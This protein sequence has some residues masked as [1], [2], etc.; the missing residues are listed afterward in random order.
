MLSQ[1]RDG[2]RYGDGGQFTTL[3]EAFISQTHDRFGYGD[4]SQT[5]ATFEA[6]LS[7]TRDG[8]GDGDGSQTDATREFASRFVSAICKLNGRKVMMEILERMKK[9]KI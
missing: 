9:K 3:A 1:T 2:I 7:Q 8:F 5:A 6:S 4:G